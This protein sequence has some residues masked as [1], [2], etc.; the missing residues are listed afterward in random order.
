MTTEREELLYFT[1]QAERIR[2]SWEPWRAAPIEEQAEEIRERL[3]YFEDLHQ[4]IISLSSDRVSAGVAWA[5]ITRQGGDSMHQ[6]SQ[7]ISLLYAR[8]LVTEEQFHELVKKL[9]FVPMVGMK[10][11]QAA[12]D[13]EKAMNDAMELVFKAVGK[14]NLDAA[15]YE[16]NKLEGFRTWDKLNDWVKNLVDLDLLPKTYLAGVRGGNHIQKML[17]IFSNKELKAGEN[18]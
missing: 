18:K 4:E 13:E 9:R 16:Y 2:K 14:V 10:A 3:A 7:L 17:S 11:R 1:R 6:C 15:R 5:E 8:N 12:A